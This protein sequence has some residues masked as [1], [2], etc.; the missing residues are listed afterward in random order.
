MAST[1]LVEQTFPV[2]GMHCGSCAAIIERTFAKAK[3]VARASAN[4]G[5]ESVRVTFDP[6]TTSPE[7][8]A[9]TLKPLGYALVVPHIAAAVTNDLATRL[10][11]GRAE[12]IAALKRRAQAAMPLAVVAILIMG[13][14]ML[15]SVQALPAPPPVWRD[16]FRHLLALMATYTLF[17]TGAAYLAAVVSFVRH[18]KANMDTLIGIG[19]GAAFVYS[20][21]LTAFEDALRSYVDVSHTYYDVTIVVIAFVTLGKFLEARAKLKTGDAIE[22]LL[23]LQAKTALVVREGAE[24]DVA[25]SDVVEGDRLIIKPGAKIPVDGVIREGRSFVDESLVTGEAAPVAKQPGDAVTS[26]TLNGAGSFTFE[27][28]RVGE[29]TFLASVVRMVE[30]AQASKAPIQALADRISA[31]FVPAVLILAVLALSGWL[32]FGIPALGFPRALGHAVTAFIGILVIACPCALGLATPTAIMVAIGKGARAGILVRNAAALERLHRADTLVLDKTGTLTRGKPELVGV[33]TF[34][35]VSEDEALSIL[36]GLE[37]R[38]EHP[39]AYAILNAAATRGVVA[40][41]V[42]AF[43]NLEGFG[44]TGTVEGRDHAA[45]NSRLMAEFAVQLP[46][47]EGDPGHTPIFLARGDQLVALFWVAD[48]VKPEA[49]A[50][51]IALRAEGV[52]PIMLTGDRRA[53]ADAIARQ[54]GITEVR[55]DLLPADKLEAIRALQADGHAVAMAGDGVN[56]APALA[57]ADVGIAMATGTDIAIETAGLTLLRGDLAR[58]VKAFR[59]S[60]LT[61]RGIKQNLFWAFAFNLAGIPLAGG[62]FYPLLGWQLSP[63]FA[64]VAMAFSSVMVISNSLRLRMVTL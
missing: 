47:G 62:L 18:G 26:G 9:K 50:A 14:D 25:I 12:E 40:R 51:L 46:V 44:V 6:G 57:Q 5:T 31:V 58:L 30:A 4:Y 48:Q 52:T 17:V 61:M 7:D 45:G 36:A 37:S 10:R 16:V 35:G 22:T 32:V 20:V 19:T 39:L 56:D 3:G 15:A 29:R 64:G 54:V 1:A 28:T 27:A 60:R 33:A 21:A 38:S 42:R 24:R 49:A 23:T 59:L 11:T 34:A 43:S 13:W 63:A 55:A 2:Q 8:L 41:E 53:T